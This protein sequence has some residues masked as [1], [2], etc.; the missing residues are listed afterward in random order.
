MNWREVKRAAVKAGF[1][2][3][4]SGGNHEIYHHP[5][6]K[7]IITLE[8]HWSQEVRPGLLKTLRKVIG[9]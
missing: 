9:F 4:R 5:D 7:R 1:V 8:R 3:Y 2:L 6:G